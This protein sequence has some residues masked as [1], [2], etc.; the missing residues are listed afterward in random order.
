VVVCVLA[1]LINSAAHA[2]PIVK[3]TICFA[4]LIGC[5]LVADNNILNEY[6]KVIPVVICGPCITASKRKPLFS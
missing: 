3:K 4:D 1:Q 5:N 6:Q 2:P